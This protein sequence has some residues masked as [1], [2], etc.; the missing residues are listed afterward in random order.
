MA[1]VLSEKQWFLREGS[2]LR[3]RWDIP[4]IEDDL[5]LLLMPKTIPSKI[6][7]EASGLSRFSYL[8][9]DHCLIDRLGFL[10]INKYSSVIHIHAK[11]QIIWVSTA[12]CR[13][14]VI[15]KRLT[16]DRKKAK[17][18]RKFNILVVLKAHEAAV[19][20]QEQHCWENMCRGGLIMKKERFKIKPNH[21]S[22]FS[23]SHMDFSAHFIQTKTLQ[24]LQLKL[25]I[26]EMVLYHGYI[27][28]SRD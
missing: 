28:Q 2:G 16:D 14:W 17:V 20:D 5:S 8:K 10:Q 4:S 1:T 6:C 19:S 12:H 21:F 15:Q 13:Q 7:H 22:L 3:K 11:K 26:F 23:V 24:V 9:R 27:Y 18:H 25:D